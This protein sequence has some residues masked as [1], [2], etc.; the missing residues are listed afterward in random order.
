M[1]S[2]ALRCAG[3]DIRCRIHAQ[4]AAAEFLKTVRFT[5]GNDRTPLID[6]AF[7]DVERPGDGR[8]GPIEGQYIGFAHAAHST[9]C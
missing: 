1:L 9:A 8:L 4:L 2:R 5:L 7:R 3:P 6:G